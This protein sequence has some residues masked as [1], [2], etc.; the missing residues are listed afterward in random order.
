MSKPFPYDLLKDPEKL[1]GM[2]GWS[3]EVYRDLLA[4][5]NGEIDEAAFRSIYLTEA[6]ILIMDMTGFTETAMGQGELVSFLRILDVQK[7][8]APVMESHSARH[9]RFFA[10]DV[11]ATFD[12]PGPALDAALELHR[13]VAVF[14][15][16]ELVGSHP[17]E[18]C[19]G[20]GYGPVFRMGLDQAMGDEMNRASKLGEDTAVGRETLITERFYERV[21]RRKGLNFEPR[22]NDELPFAF[23]S[24][25][26]KDLK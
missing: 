2:K 18:C 10:D 14:N 13:R 24:V 15:A 26:E 23:Y 25:T 1:A 7:V 4:V 11:T 5:Q 8:A 6:A 12:S 16:S 17:T 3:V 21:R 22:R 9:I 19:I 20:L